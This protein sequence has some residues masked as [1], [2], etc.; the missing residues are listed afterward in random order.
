MLKCLVL[1]IISFVV[2]PVCYS[3][4]T[5]IKIGNIAI[6]RLSRRRSLASWIFKV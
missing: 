3:I 5:F 6:S 2:V 1:V 4:Q